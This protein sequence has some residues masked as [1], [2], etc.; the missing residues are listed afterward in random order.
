ML[1]ANV[2]DIAEDVRNWVE[3]LARKRKDIFNAG[4]SGYCAI[5]SAEL[6]RRLTA[7]GIEAELQ[8][9]STQEAS[10]AY[11]VCEDYI[12]DVTATQFSEFRQ[13][14]IVIL[15]TKEAERYWFYRGEFVFD[16]AN[17]MRK[18]QI[19]WGWPQEQIALTR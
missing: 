16:N 7:A 9:A 10:H 13:Q 5:A 8:I 6:Y 19:S 4:L 2:Y 17:K 14:H 11:V 18:A 3:N 15:H 12:I 1:A